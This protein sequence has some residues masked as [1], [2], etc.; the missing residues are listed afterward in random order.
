[1]HC[2]GPAFLSVSLVHSQWPVLICILA[3]VSRKLQLATQYKEY[4]FWSCQGQSQKLSLELASYIINFSKNLL[5]K[6]W[7]K[8]FE[9]LNL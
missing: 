1:M 9:I 7:N 3:H 8:I 5:K 6:G 4:R 2:T